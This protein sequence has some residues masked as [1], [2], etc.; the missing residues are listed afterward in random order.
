MALHA[1]LKAAWWS[2]RDE[3][4]GAPSLAGLVEGSYYLVGAVAHARYLAHAQ[5]E[6][7]ELLAHKGRIG[8][9]DLPVEQFVADCHDF[10]VH[11]VE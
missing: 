4:E 3:P 5:A 9:H 11:R 2:T 10:N 1:R 6:A 8:I 7:A